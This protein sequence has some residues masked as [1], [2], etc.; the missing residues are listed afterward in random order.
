MG[1][2][3][4]KKAIEKFPQVINEALVKKSLSVAEID[5]FIP[6][7]TNLPIAQ[8]IKKQLNLPS[9]K[10]FSKIERFGNTTAAKYFYG[11]VRSMGD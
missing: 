6:R 11:T 2:L 5:M 3:F 10:V 4:L 7:Q 8:L 9:E 1:R